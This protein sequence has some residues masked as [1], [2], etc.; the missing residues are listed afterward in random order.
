M[1]R[2]SFSSIVD[3]QLPEFIRDEYPLFVK[4]IQKYYEWLEQPTNV[5]KES[6]EIRDSFDVDLA[7]DVYLERIKQDLLPYFPELL[8]VDKNSLL[9]FAN[10][11][12]ASK[13]TPQSLKF[14]FRAVFNED[15]EIFYPKDDILRA[16]DGKW[17]LPLALRID[18]NDVNILNIENCLLIGETSKATALVETVTRSVDRQLGISYIELYVSNVKRLF[19]TGEIVQATYND[20]ITDIVVRGKLIGALSQINI[21]RNARGLFYNAYD[22]ATGYAGDPVTIVGGL[23]PT[24][25]NPIGAIAYVGSTTLGSITD[26][27]VTDGGFGFR[28]PGEN[29]QNPDISLIDFKGGFENALFGTEAK[30]QISLVDSSTTRVMNVSS[31]QLE[32]VFYKTLDELSPVS[33]SVN[34]TITTVSSYQSFNVYP[35]SFI[36]LTGSGG[37]YRN[38]PEVDVYSF[39]NESSPDVLVVSGANI[40]KGTSAI[41]I[42]GTD[43]RVSFEPGDIARLFVN[44]KL[45]AIRIVTGV[46]ANTLS[47]GETFQNDI[48]EVIIYK[49]SRNDMRD[50]G[51]LGRLQIVNGGENYAV[52]EYLVFTGGS[53]Y[54]ANAR[55]SEVH[56]SNNGIKAVQFMQTNDYVIGGEGYRQDALPTITVNSVSGANASIVPLEISGEGEDIALTTSRIGAIST[57][58]IISYG[59]DYVS[60][61]QISLRNADLVVAN[62]TPG[63]VFVSNTKVY[64]GTTNTI[65]TFSA[66]VDSYDDETG[67]LR[68]FNYKGSFDHLK[69]IKSDDGTIEA[70]IVTHKFYGDGQAKATADFENGLIR[71]PGLYLNTDGHL[72]EDKYL[73]DGKKYHNF[74]YEL[75]TKIDYEKFEETVK[76]VV[77]PAGM[78]AFINKI[79]ETSDILTANL[80]NQI[81]IEYSLPNT[82]NVTNGTLN[83]VS[84]NTSINVAN[85]VSVGDHVILGNVVIPFGNTVNTQAGSNVITSTGNNFNFMNLLTED[86]EIIVYRGIQYEQFKDVSAQETGVTEV[87]FNNS[88]NTMYI[89]G[90]AGDDITYYNL[91]SPWNVSTATA[92]SQRSLAPQTTAPLGMFIKP[93]GTTIWVTSNAPSNNVITYTMTQ[94]WNVQTIT[95]QSSQTLNVTSQTS[96]ATGIYW[97]NDGTKFYISSSSG[98]IN[99]TILEYTASQAWNVATGTLTNR[100]L[101]TTEETTVQGLTFADDGSKMFIVGSVSNK[102][103]YYELSIPWNV[104]SASLIRSIPIETVPIG[105]NYQSTPGKLY[106]IHDKGNTTNT[107]IVMQYLYDFNENRQKIISIDRANTITMQNTISYTSSNVYIDKV[108]NDVKRVMNVNTTTILVDTKFSTNTRFVGTSIRK[109]E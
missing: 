104:A 74:S 46:T 85:S 65:P 93:D 32:T 71:Y 101:I 58:R 60:A 90:A 57:L 59:Y 22:P 102:L 31:T 103:H 89:L 30:A 25:N 82:F 61:P 47:F 79:Q 23:N 83:M 44:N 70:D 88:G 76:N 108:F 49:V 84:T 41:T 109:V 7:S 66:F 48:S 81:F 94:P 100:R 9:K 68:I 97:K 75:N 8:S 16:S 1:T 37:G 87:T 15:V 64:Q 26:I 10:Q 54:G 73:Q 3:R 36:L 42:F 77:H 78:V 33:N 67:F 27:V 24:S 18:T 63:F 20:G 50:I 96:A 107:N 51:S 40:V 35:I 29:A 86:D 91:S 43:L 56:T 21:N 98:T 12:Y 72:S 62:A 13:G 28:D 106:L 39:Y 11:F 105:I 92:V 17:A 52:G 55:I 80:R 2:T 99:D 95:A 45:D 19:Q 6:E 53:G 34:T 38:K 5:L 14:L 69:K 4:F